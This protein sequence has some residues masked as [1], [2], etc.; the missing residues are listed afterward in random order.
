VV[1]L[2]L[3]RRMILSGHTLVVALNTTKGRYKTYPYLIGNERFT[4]FNLNLRGM[5]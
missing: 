4:P 5:L 2:K 1:A 3:N